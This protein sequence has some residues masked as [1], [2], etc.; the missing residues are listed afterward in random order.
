MALFGSI[1]KQKLIQQALG[2]LWD[3]FRTRK[4]W[5][6]FIQGF[7]KGRHPPTRFYSM[8]GMHPTTRQKSNHKTGIQPL[9][10]HPAT[11]QAFNH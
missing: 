11:R 4:L 5:V 3:A 9:D 2:S 10:K 7:K 8:S 6:S 1:F